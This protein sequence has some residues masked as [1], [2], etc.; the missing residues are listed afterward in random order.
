VR[1]REALRLQAQ[2]RA[3]V[4]IQAACRGHQVRQLRR[5]QV[6]AAVKIQAAWRRASKRGGYLLFLW[7]YAGHAY[8][9]AFDWHEWG[10]GLAG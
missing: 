5:G 8:R 7:V 2:E 3:A 10:K 9:H 6:A 4:R 1:Y